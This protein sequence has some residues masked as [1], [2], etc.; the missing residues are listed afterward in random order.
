M[1]R[2]VPLVALAL[3]GSAAT[4]PAR[5]DYGV[6]AI[7]N[8]FQ[9]AVSTQ[10]R[11]PDGGRR[12]DPPN[13]GLLVQERQKTDYDRPVSDPRSKSSKTLPAGTSTNPSTKPPDQVGR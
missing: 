6:R 1:M 10:Y 2:V 5:A 3:L 9:P 13:T 11:P 4:G 12:Y 7:W 8:D